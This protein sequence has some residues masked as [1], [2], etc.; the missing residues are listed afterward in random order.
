MPRPPASGY[1]R[2]AQDA[3]LSDSDNEFEDDN[4]RS[5]IVSIRPPATSRHSREPFSP[6]ILVEGR[7][8][9]RMRRNSSSS[10]VDIKA[11]NAR[12]ERWAEEIASKF[13][14]GKQKGRSL[15][16]ESPLE[17]VYSVF[18]P[19]E[20]YRP[21]LSSAT[22]DPRENGHITKEQFD[23]LFEA[24]RAAISKGIEPKL[25]K[26]GSSGSYFMRTSGGKV[27]GVFKPKDEEPYVSN[28]VFCS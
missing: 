3:E 4:F 26:Q 6:P 10:G 15:Q 23:E 12:L 27:V 20:G 21:V 1:E 14:I 19:P 22:L 24:V 17:I 2:L 9:P 11:I 25:I 16:D 28:T 7:V 13:K 18:V 5:R 8:G